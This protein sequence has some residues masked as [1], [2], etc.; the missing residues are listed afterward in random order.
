MLDRYGPRKVQTV[1]LAM[2]GI[3]SALFPAEELPHVFEFSY[4]HTTLQVLKVDRGWTNLQVAYPQPFDP[5]PVLRQLERFG[6]AFLEV[7]RGAA[8]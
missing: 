7:I 8:R 5:A 1:L 6:D 4:N 2:A 3:G